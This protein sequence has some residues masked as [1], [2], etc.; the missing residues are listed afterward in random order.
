MKR[1]PLVLLLPLLAQA[2]D[3]I[4]LSLRRAV[5]IALAPEGSARLQL[6]REA[7]RAAEARAGQARA[8]LLPDLSA[9]LLYASQTTNLAA[10]GIQFTSPFPGF[11]IPSFV[12]PFTTFDARVT[13]TQSIFDF[14]ALRRMQSARRTVDSVHSESGSA[15]DTTTE[16]VARAYLAALRAQAS[17]ETADANVKLGEELVNLA[18][19]QRKAGTGTGIE[20]TRAQV[21]LANEKQRRIVMENESERARL[22]LLRT[23][24]LRLDAQITLTDALAYQPTEEITVAQALETARKLRDA[25]AAQERREE[26]ARLT[27]DAVKWE[28]LPSLAAFADYGSLGSGLG[29]TLPTRSYG[30]SLRVPIFDGGRR[31]ARR[32]EAASLYR[33]ERIR[34]RD[35]REQIEL[36]IRLALDALRSAGAQVG[37][38]R[39]GLALAESELA[40][41]RRRYE[42][43][44]ASSIEVTDAQTRLARARDN[45]VSALFNHNLARLDLNAAQGAVE[46]ILP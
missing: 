36:D 37:T 12:G 23:I 45:M 17:V 30:L 16:L 10:R 2:Q 43:G 1:V 28:R 31:D 35:L 21:Q 11:S 26:A 20:V 13:G 14:A 25:L 40:S 34:T 33:Q 9:S 42:A 41:A 6:A 46:R 22:Q 44:V 29:S 24:G 19:T 7:V 15:A 38:S 32:A 8:A 27:F 4:P 5:E 3:A 39:E 18:E